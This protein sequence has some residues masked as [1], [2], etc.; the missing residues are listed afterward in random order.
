M[1]KSKGYKGASVARTIRDEVARHFDDTVTTSGFSKPSA[2][3]RVFDNVEKQLAVP[4]ADIYN[5]EPHTSIQRDTE[6]R[7][8]CAH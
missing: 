1:F 8:H 7:F 5:R 4:N 3:Q 6:D 2:M